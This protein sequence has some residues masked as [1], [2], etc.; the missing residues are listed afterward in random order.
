[1]LVKDK[2]I[3]VED[4]EKKDGDNAEKSPAPQKP[5]R[6]K[7]KKENMRAAWGDA[8]DYYIRGITEKYLLF[9]GRASRLEFWGYAAGRNY[10]DTALFCRRICGDAASAVLLCLGD[11]AADSGGYGKAPA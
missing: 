10:V 8:F 1:M 4:P 9:R 11:A 6:P 5:Q 7:I 3:L 2:D